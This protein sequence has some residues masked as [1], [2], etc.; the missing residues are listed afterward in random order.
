MCLNISFREIS[1]SIYEL[2]HFNDLACGVVLGLDGQAV[3]IVTVHYDLEYGSII[4]IIRLAVY[5]AVIKIIVFD[6]AP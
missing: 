1:V 2:I 4:L 5:A 3:G 6:P